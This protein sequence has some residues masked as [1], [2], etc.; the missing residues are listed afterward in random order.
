MGHF[1]FSPCDNST[2]QVLSIIPILQM[3]KQKGLIKLKET[4][5]PSPVVQQVKALALSPQRPRSLWWCGFDPGP[6]ELPHA[7]GGAKSKIK[8]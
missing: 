7:T 4:D 1:S 2:Q 6:W 5:R 8:K 3:K